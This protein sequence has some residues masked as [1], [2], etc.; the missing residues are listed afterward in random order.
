MKKKEDSWFTYVCCGM[1]TLPKLSFALYQVLNKSYEENMLH[2][3][4]FFTVISIRG[5]S[6]LL[7]TRTD[8]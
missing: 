5:S 2:Q 7:L 1:N 4:C 6:N 8:F 3:V